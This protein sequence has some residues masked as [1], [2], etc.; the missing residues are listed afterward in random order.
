MIPDRVAVVMKPEWVKTGRFE[1]KE[2]MTY[3]REELNIRFP[4]AEWELEELAPRDYLAWFRL[5]A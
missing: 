3:C 1:A 4:D 5:K 2:L